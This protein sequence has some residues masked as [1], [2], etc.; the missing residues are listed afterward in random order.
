MK[1]RVVVTGVGLVSPLGTGV[2]S[3]WSR[4]LAGHCAVSSLE[5]EEFASLPSKIAARVPWGNDDPMLFNPAD[6]L[7]P[8]ERKNQPACLLY[9]MSACVQALQ[10]ADWFPQSEQLKQRTGVAIGSGIGGVQDLITAH[11][12]LIQKGYRRVSPF[13][14]PHT[15]VNMAADTIWLSGTKS[16]SIDCLCHRRPLYW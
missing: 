10:D 3:C 1:R 4:L 9:S 16:F 5:G 7:Q 2:A 11:D 14:I 13:M 8:R 12:A 6:W 15:L